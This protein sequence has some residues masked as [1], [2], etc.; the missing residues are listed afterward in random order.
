MALTANAFILLSDL[1]A[2][3]GISGSNQDVQ[4]L[5]A[6]SYAS[7]LIESFL[8]RKIPTRGSLTEYHT[9]EWPCSCDLYLG[10]FPIISVTSVHED[11]TRTYGAPTLL[12]VDTD[13]IVS[14][15]TGKLVRVQAGA[16]ALYWQ[17]GFRPVKVIY[18]AGYLV[19]G[20]TTPVGATAIP[21]DLAQVCAEMAATIFQDA[22]RKEWGK[23]QMS[24]QDRTIT[25]VT[26]YMTDDL[27]ARL[28]PYQR[29]EFS[30]TWDRD[31]A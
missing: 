5:K 17:S 11:T 10:E 4:L 25:R 15:P 26:G 14:K 2:F 3:M 30:R 12:V 18:E 27:K 20:A 19:P 31:V 7:A 1:K 16:G 22:D 29:R 9:L 24:S 28:S 6:I 8:D 21:E 23:V 13:Y